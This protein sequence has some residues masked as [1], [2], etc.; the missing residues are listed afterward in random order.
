MVEF[1]IKRKERERFMAM[2]TKIWTL[3]T[4]LKQVAVRVCS[5]SNLIGARRKPGGRRPGNPISR[6]VT[7]NRFIVRRRHRFRLSLFDFSLSASLLLAIQCKR[8]DLTPPIPRLLSLLD[9]SATI[10][11]PLELY[12]DES[13]NGR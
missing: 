2:V 12:P 6:R 1:G 7:K 10:H 3:S 11:S 8:A 4:E 13:L 5:A 9:R